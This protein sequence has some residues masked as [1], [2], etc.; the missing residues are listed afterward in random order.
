MKERSSPFFLPSAWLVL[1]INKVHVNKFNSDKFNQPRTTLIKSLTRAI[2]KS[3]G[4]EIKHSW[5]RGYHVL[6][7]PGPLP[8]HQHFQYKI[9]PSHCTPT[10]LSLLPFPAL[11]TH[12]MPLHLWC[13]MFPYPRVSILEKDLEYF[14]MIMCR[15]YKVLVRFVTLALLKR[16][17]QGTD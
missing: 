14:S 9:T 3:W 5:H 10:R 2:W 1:P 11:L 8:P 13:L 7:L 12:P 6:T 15:S 17:S 4:R 16:N